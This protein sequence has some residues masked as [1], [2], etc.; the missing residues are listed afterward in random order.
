MKPFFEARQLTYAYPRGPLAVRNVS[1][2]VLPA[3]MTAVIGA[4]G[5]GKSTLVRILAGLLKPASGEVMLD[6]VRLD[7]WEPRSLAREIA[8]MPQP[9]PAV[10][11]FR[12]VDLVLTGRSPHIA[13]FHLD[14]L[15]PGETVHYVRYRLDYMEGAPSA[16]A[17]RG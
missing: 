13:R 11:P 14:A 17:P 16:A 5:S 7:D 3:S 6:G 1:L 8:Y 9:T 15:S 4:N 12:V 10:F 2:E